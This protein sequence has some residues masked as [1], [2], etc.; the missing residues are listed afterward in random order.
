M[1]HLTKD[2][3]RVV[4]NNLYFRAIFF[5]IP[6]NNIHFRYKYFEVIAAILKYNMWRLLIIILFGPKKEHYKRIVIETIYI[7]EY[8]TLI[9]EMCVASTV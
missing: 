2:V 3:L 6:Y 5:N 9:F 8:N 4:T 1:W 7:K